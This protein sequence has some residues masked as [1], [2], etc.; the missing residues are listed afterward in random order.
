MFGWL[1][2]K[3]KTEIEKLEEEYKA[4]MQKSFELSR[5]DRKASDAAALEANEI[6]QRIEELSKQAASQS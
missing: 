2:G 5:T 1:F 4:L 3:K 6:Q